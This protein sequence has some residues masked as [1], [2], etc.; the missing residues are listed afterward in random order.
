[1]SCDKCEREPARGVFVRVGNANVE[2]VA[3][4][5]HCRQVIEKLRGASQSAQEIAELKAAIVGLR[6]ALRKMGQDFFDLVKKVE[7]GVM[8]EDGVDGSV[9]DW[10]LA[11]SLRYVESDILSKTNSQLVAEVRA[12]VLE[13][14]ITAIEGRSFK[15]TREIKFP[16]WIRDVIDR[17]IQEAE[18]KSKDGEHK[19]GCGCEDGAHEPDCRQNPIMIQAKRKSKGE[20]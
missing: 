7:D 19:M 15:C 12:R 3:C 1:M 5:E 6:D 2:V 16:R 18:R 10:A 17:M 13:G 14:V 11:Q 20:G 8:S 4:M 9:L